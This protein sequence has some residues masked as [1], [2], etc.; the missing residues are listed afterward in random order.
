LEYDDLIEST[1]GYQVR[2]NYH[3]DP[4]V[5]GIDWSTIP[6][7]LG[8]NEVNRRDDSKDLV[9][10][11]N[12]DTWYPLLSIREYGKGKVSAWMTGASPHWGINFVKWK[13]YNKFWQQL[14]TN[15]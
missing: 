14:F 1:A 13:E 7:I 11:K 12:E 4:I 15:I 6:P 3:Q 10:I 5:A 2:T 9:E 8:F